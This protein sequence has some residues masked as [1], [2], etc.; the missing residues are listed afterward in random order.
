M[1]RATSTLLPPLSNNFALV[2]L[3]WTSRCKLR[4]GARC[5]AA[6]AARPRM[7]ERSFPPQA[8]KMMTHG[9][10]LQWRRPKSNRRR[11]MR[12]PAGREASRARALRLLQR[13]ALRLPPRRLQPRRR[14]PARPRTRRNPRLLL[15]PR[16]RLP[17]QRLLGN[18][19]RPRQSRP[20]ALGLLA[21]CG[22]SRSKCPPASTG[23]R[24]WRRCSLRPG[25]ASRP[26]RACSLE[27]VPTWPVH[28]EARRAHVVLTCARGCVIIVHTC[29]A[30]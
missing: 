23:P 16:R 19:L 18:P 29:A 15:L 28:L 7:W 14:L 26:A 13:Q 5:C 24:A 27:S 6:V 30:Q 4:L 25:S 8:K 20:Q 22:T 21:A 2:C 17:R 3:V 10:R 9:R 1:T 11:T 12:Q